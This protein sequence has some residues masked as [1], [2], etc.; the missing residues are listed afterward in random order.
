VS[1][2]VVAA[3]AMLFMAATLMAQEGPVLR[4]PHATEQTPAVS[5][6]VKLVNVPFVARD[7]KGKIVNLTKGDLQ[8]TDDGQPQTI[9]N[10]VQESDLPLTLGLLVDTSSAQR[11]SLDK[12]RAAGKA[13]IE[14]L[15]REGKDQAFLIHFD[16]QVELL[17]D[18]TSSR[19]KLRDAIDTLEV[20]N[21]PARGEDDD[22]SGGQQPPGRN[23]GGGYPGGGYPGGHGGHGGQSHIFYGTT[24]NDALFLASDELLAKPEG[25][26]VLI[27]LS[28]GMDHASKVS[29]ERALESAQSNDV[30]VYSVYF[31]GQTPQERE[32][33]DGGYPGGGRGRY[34]GGGYPGGGYPGGGY[35]GGGYPG[36]GYPGGGY[37]GDDGSR[38]DPK[39]MREEGKKNLQRIAKETGGRYF[40]FNKKQNVEQIYNDIQDDL[41]NQCRLTYTPDHPTAG[42]HKIAVSAVSKDVT[43]QAREGYYV[44]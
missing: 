16:R 12:E 2:R 38:Q 32:R 5:S 14:Q 37:P 33:M 42:Y 15:L 10:L 18:M 40:E 44:K 25:R 9:K 34:P 23:P 4:K 26:K 21:R 39:Q 6:E 22:Q 7:K 1:T 29:L 43:V 3:M 17:Q 8:V 30:L 35:P 41:R 20:A 28:D 13:L 11:G 27:V 24:L 36:G 19:A 31:E